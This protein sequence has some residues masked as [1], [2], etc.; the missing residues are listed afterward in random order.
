MNSSTDQDHRLNLQSIYGALFFGVP[1]QGM[2]V[3]AMASMV[4]GL[5]AR[6]TLNLL[7]QQL[8]FRLRNRQ[9]EDFCK[10]FSFRDS[11]IIQ[12]FE[13]TKTP[14]VTQVSYFA[15]ILWDTKLRRTTNRRAGLATVHPRYSSILSRRPTGDYGR[16]EMITLSHSMGITRLWSNSRLTTGMGTRRCAI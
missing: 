4:E 9:H 10:A 8:G 11:K 12:F 14:T 16:L 6:Y 15:C 2:N 7:D 1:S 5:P 3:E 13:L